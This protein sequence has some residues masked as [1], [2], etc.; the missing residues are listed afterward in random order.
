MEDILEYVQGIVYETDIIDYPVAFSGTCFPI[1]WGDVLFVITARHCFENKKT[2]NEDRGRFYYHLPQ[3]S[4]DAVRFSIFYDVK[5]ELGNISEKYQDIIIAVPKK[6]EECIQ[7]VSQIC[8][9][10]ISNPMV[11][12]SLDYFDQSNFKNRDIRDNLDGVVVKGFPFATR[13]IDYDEHNIKIQGV[14]LEDCVEVRKSEFKECYYLKFNDPSFFVE[15]GN[16]VLGCDANGLSGSP[17]YFYD[18]RN[19][20]IFLLGMVIEYNT[21]SEEFLVISS[22]VISS[23]VK[24]VVVS[25]GLCEASRQDVGKRLEPV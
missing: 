15:A 10:D 24:E 25:E 22:R 17:V 21:L 2:L 5:A 23:V 16:H 9:L 14:R 11:C 12:Q 1:R 8:A 7:D 18:R 4:T 19:C 3:K 13:K 6:Q 20:N